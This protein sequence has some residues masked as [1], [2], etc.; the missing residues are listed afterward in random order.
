MRN[1]A[2]LLAM[3][4]F[5]ARVSPVLDWCS[6]AL[7]LAVESPD[8]ASGRELDLRETG[9]FECLR[10]LR[11][12]G[13]MTLICGALSLELLH[14]GEILGLR[15]FPGVAGEIGDVLQAYR[16]DL[17]NEPRFRLPGYRCFPYGRRAA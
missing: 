14:Y 2:H 13:V 3:P 15:I 4:I 10:F 11:E 12:E 8:V 5:R 1:K 16:N 7:I 6:K 9:P 17:L